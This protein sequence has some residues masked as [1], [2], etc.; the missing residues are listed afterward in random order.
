MRERCGN[1]L[2]R[3]TAEQRAMLVG[4][5]DFFGLNHYSSHLCE[6]PAWYKELAPQQDEEEREGKLVGFRVEESSMLGFRKHAGVLVQ[7]GWSTKT[8]Y[9]MRAAS[10][11][12]TPAVA[13]TS[14]CMHGTLS[15]ALL[16]LH[17]HPLHTGNLLA[18]HAYMASHGIHTLQGTTSSHDA[19]WAQCCCCCQHAARHANDS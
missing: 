11:C 2:P 9:D 19:A 12:T 1:R 16:L 14:S 6:Q 18:C 10:V 4:S 3:F 13:C 8:M 7:M 15:P 17:L 5:V